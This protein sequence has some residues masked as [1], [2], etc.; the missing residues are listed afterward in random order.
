ML[1]EIDSG[2]N[3]SEDATG[4]SDTTSFD[5]ATDDS[6]QVVGVFV[7]VLQCHTLNQPPDGTTNH[8]ARTRSP[9]SSLFGSLSPS[10]PNRPVI[11]RW[12]PRRLYYN[13]KRFPG[14]RRELWPS[15]DENVFGGGCCVLSTEVMFRVKFSPSEIVN[16]AEGG[17]VLAPI[18][19]LFDKPLFDHDGSTTTYDQ[20]IILA[21]S[22]RQK[23]QE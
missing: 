12:V 20:T 18:T 21:N 16:S 9:W 15:V 4:L 14:N 13:R 8:S 17:F 5:V 7:K 23:V 19:P 1:H 6:D 3:P 11:P 2:N 22:L 10:R